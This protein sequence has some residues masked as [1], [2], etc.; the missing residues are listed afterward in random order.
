MAERRF[1]P[2]GAFETGT[3]V[4]SRFADLAFLFMFNTYF[5]ATV[6]RSQVTCFFSGQ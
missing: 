2:L 3:G 1:R 4:T 5:E 6:N